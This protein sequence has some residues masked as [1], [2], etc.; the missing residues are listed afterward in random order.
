MQ[1]YESECSYSSEE[2]EQFQTEVKHL[3]IQ[4]K[5]LKVNICPSPLPS[6]LPC[7]HQ[8]PRPRPA[9]S[10]HITGI[11]RSNQTF[12]HSQFSILRS[13]RHRCC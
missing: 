6:P 1:T 4:M 3:Q 2:L 8:P 5:Q 7:Q 9:L 11:Q 13:T 10:Y 12:T